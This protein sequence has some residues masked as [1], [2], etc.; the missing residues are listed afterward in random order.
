M[1]YGG[2]QPSWYFS[3]EGQTV[4]WSQ[5]ERFGFGHEFAWLTGV[6]VDVGAAAVSLDYVLQITPYGEESGYSIGL[7]LGG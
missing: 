1:V 3:G 6:S 2:L 4:A 7:K 5:Q